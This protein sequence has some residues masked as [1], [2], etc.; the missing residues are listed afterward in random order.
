MGLQLWLYFCYGN[1]QCRC[2]TQ[3]DKGKACMDVLSRGILPSLADNLAF[4]FWTTILTVTLTGE[5][6]GPGQLDSWAEMG[7]RNTKLWRQFFGI[8]TSDRNRRVED[9]IRI[10]IRPARCR[11]AHTH[12]GYVAWQ[13]NLLDHT[14]IS[15]PRLC[16]DARGRRCRS[17]SRLAD[18]YDPSP[19][20]S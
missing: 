14:R 5:E 16:G 20:F 15:R 3:D 6:E 12:P 17:D 10:Q 1:N 7:K 8:K 11:G 4:D 13:Q 2:A 9:P 18:A 19:R